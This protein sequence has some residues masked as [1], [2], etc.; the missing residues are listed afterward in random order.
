MEALLKVLAPMLVFTYECFDRIV[1]NAYWSVLMRPGNVVYFFQRVCGIA[2]ITKEVLA[3]RTRV[4]QNWVEAFARNHKIAIEWAEDERKEDAVRGHLRAFERANRFGVYFIYKSME[5]GTTF[6]SV[7]PKFDTGDPNY[8]ILKRSR[9]RYTHYYFYIRDAV[10]GPMVLRV[11]SFL[12]FAATAYLNGHSFIERR[13]RKAGAAFR[14]NDNA[15]LATADPAALQAAA[16]ALTPEIIQARLDYWLHI[17]GPKLSPRER[18]AMKIH[19]FYFLSQVEYCRNFIFRRHFPIRRLFERGCELGL[20]RLTADRIAHI[21]GW[22][23]TRTFKGKLQSVLERVDHGHQVLRAYCKNSFAKMYEKFRTF[24]RLEVCSNNVRD[25]RLKKALA[26]LPAF[27]QAARTVLDRFAH[28]LAPT[29][30]VHLD[31]PLLQRLALPIPCGALR[32]PGIKLHETRMIRLL[33]TL[34]HAGTFL[35]GWTARQLHEAIVRT[36]D[37]PHYT[38]TQLRYDLRKLKAHGLLERTGRAYRLT[39]KGRK[40]AVLFVLFHKRLC[41][42]LAHTLFEQHLP[43]DAQPLTP[44]EDVYRRADTAIQNIIDFLENSRSKK[45]ILRCAA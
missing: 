39:D 10:L 13:L 23:V 30:Q 44:L 12:P 27:A 36:Y 17:V 5:Q 19:R 2:C 25:L 24:L 4:Y 37:Q 40:V 45:E 38:I 22:R 34:L 33:E 9:S 14:K 18:A 15:F 35:T 8:R 3:A 29:L 21:F 20:L 26:N 43:T 42:P 16:D 6:R 1:I 32:L 28:V 31:F 41:G 11:G 7:V